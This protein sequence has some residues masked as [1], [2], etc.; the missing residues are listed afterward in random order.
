VSTGVPSENVAA[1]V[2]AEV[3]G[4]DLLVYGH[5]HQMM[6][7]TTIGSTLLMQPKNWATSVGV[8]TLTVE[9]IGS[10]WRVTRKRGALVPVAGHPEQPAMAAL[11]DAAHR[12]TREYVQTTVGTTSVAWRGDSAR[13]ADVPLID[14]IL[15]TE[16]R[17]AGTDLAST[18]AFSLDAALD[19]GPITIAELARLYPYDNTLRAVRITGRQL[20]EYLEQSARYYRTVAPSG[21]ADA[22]PLIDPTIPGYNFD[23]VSG[24]DYVIDLRRPVGSRIT[25]LTRRGVPVSDS[26]SF[27]MALNNY[28]QTGGGGYAMLADAPV[29]YDRQEEIRQLL[30][31]EVRRRG[32]LSPTDYPERNWRLEP[33][34]AVARVYAEQRGA[35]AAP[36]AATGVGTATPPIDTTQAGRSQR[37]LRIISTNDFHG[38]LDARVDAAG[39]RTG[40]GSALAA[41]IDRART[42]CRPG[43]ETILLDGGDE[44]Q[45]TPMSNL[46]FG[47]RVV[48]LFNLLDYAGA[49]VGNHEFDWGTDTLRAR[50]GEARY[51]MMAANVR[52]TDGRDVEW[53]RN[54]TIVTRGSL[55]IG[56]IGLATQ[57]TPI[58]TRARNVAGLR[59]DPPA[60]I[61]DSIAR[62]LRSR[63]AN[64]VIV[65]GHVGGVCAIDAASSCNGEIFQLAQAL[66]EPIDA[67]VSGHSH[68][69][70][71]TQVRGIPIVQAR[72]SART[73]A[74]L[75][76][77]LDAPA[78]SR[79]VRA[80]LR[81]VLADSLPPVRVVD[82]MVTRWRN[83]I[84]SQV[85]QPVARF[86]TAMTKSGTQYALGN[87][88][89][90]AQRWA[91]KADVAVM[92]N[93]G[94]R[95]DLLAGQATYGTLF[96]IQPFA[97]ILSRAS[98]PGSALREYLERIVSRQALNAHVSGVTVHY[99]P[100]KPAGSRILD[101]RMSDGKPLD[102]RATYTI[103]INDFLVTGGDALA[104]PA[105][106]SPAVSLDIIDLEALIDYARSRPQPVVA[107]TE[108]RL[109]PR[110]K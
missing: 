50:M 78:G 74:V 4:I 39:V 48:E 23:I 33:A 106:A 24:V 30:I 49:A 94:I 84:A 92:N 28:R 55:R 75:D 14:F 103:A 10:A 38:A 72:S 90:D 83:A 77:P 35:I 44:F 64:F 80:E 61:V 29:V 91:A 13:V 54:D 62:V 40:G 67:I 102:D 27:T 98:L 104:L 97:N 100:T 12:A 110:P 22:G 93:G 46:S 42:E 89:A 17:V 21:Q 9:R 63:G 36:T 66:T 82:S 69:A 6:A 15:E 68:S 107:P 37:R 47:R 26:D 53:I 3:A 79:V 57:S 99:D 34:D 41:A 11:T 52:Y 81:P 5:S 86:A 56:V 19:A 95:T 88:V 109:I 31:D 105:G 108:I 87:F 59:F 51:R 76:I 1:R 85:N 65:V 8:A 25:S 73:I 58:T 20:R 45:G 96:E 16:R 7:D 32:T 43:C 101:V 2:A 71:D 60:P 18:A 70:L